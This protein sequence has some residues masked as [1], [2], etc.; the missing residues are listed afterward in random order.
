MTRDE[1]LTEYGRHPS[2]PSLQGLEVNVRKRQGG[3]TATEV[4]IRLRP[5]K[6]GLGPSDEVAPV[7]S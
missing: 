6:G 2:Y 1:F 5:R 7:T 3:L 4:T